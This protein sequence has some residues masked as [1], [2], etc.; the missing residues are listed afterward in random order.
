MERKFEF[1]HGGIYSMQFS[2]DGEKLVLGYGNGGIDVSNICSPYF[3]YYRVI[4]YS[5]MANEGYHHNKA[6][7]YCMN[8]MPY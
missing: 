8:K 2:Y 7:K 5:H 1:D 4:S 3:F 6:M